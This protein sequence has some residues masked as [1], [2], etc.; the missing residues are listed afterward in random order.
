[1]Y[2]PANT[3]FS[4]DINGVK[5]Q[6]GNTTMMLFSFDKIISYISRFFTL[7]TGDLIFTGTPAGVGA[8][9]CG[10]VLEGFLENEKVLECKIK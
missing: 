2:Q 1:H 6:Q 4:L 3:S 9:K 10:D 5:V 7:Q 8:I